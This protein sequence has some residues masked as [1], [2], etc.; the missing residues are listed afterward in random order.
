MSSRYRAWPVP[1]RRTTVARWLLRISTAPAPKQFLAI[2]PRANGKRCWKSRRW[3]SRLARL[4]AT[5]GLEI[6]GVLAIRPFSALRPG[7][8]WNFHRHTLFRRSESSPADRRCGP[9]PVNGRRRGCGTVLRAA[10]TCI[11]QTTNIHHV[12]ALSVPYYPPQV[13]TASRYGTLNS[14]LQ[15]R[16]QSACHCAIGVPVAQ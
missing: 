2:Y 5:K 15:A 11:T 12:P 8:L 9:H 3:C 16:R 4:R 10:P 1:H 6:V 7:E 13:F 14:L